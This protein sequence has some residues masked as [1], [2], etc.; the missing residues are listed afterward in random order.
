M[1]LKLG[2]M[3]VTSPAFA[4]GEPMAKKYAGDGDNLSPPLEWSGAPNGT[5][6]FA[7]ICH[8]PDAPLPHGF[9]HWVVCGIPASV[10]TLPEGQKP[11]IFVPGVNSTGKQ[12]YMGPYPPN[13]HGLH[14]Y[15]FWVYALGEDLKLKPGVNRA[16]LLH[17]IDAH[18]L[19]QARIVG[20][21][22]R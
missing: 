12:G 15:Y 5:K 20:T 11:D 13:G 17:A 2:N 6:Q 16:Q 4:T 1:S 8:D 21:Y 7:L 18:Y 9:T 14:R 10:T 3:R 19:E 22:Q